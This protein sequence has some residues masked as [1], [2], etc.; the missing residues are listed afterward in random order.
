[1]G[2]KFQASNHPLVILASQPPS[3]APPRVPSSEQKA[4]GHGSPVSALRVEAER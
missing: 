4:L 1:M 3:K 2:L